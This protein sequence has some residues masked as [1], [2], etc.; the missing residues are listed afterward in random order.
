MFTL[1]A[2]DINIIYSHD[3]TISL[4]NIINT[5]LEKLYAWFNFNKLS[6]NFRKTN[7]VAFS[8]NN[9]DSIIDISVNGS[10]IEK[11]NSAKY[12]GVYVDRRLN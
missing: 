3:S 5:E 6:L 7:Y 8:T 9:L 12:L 4:C 2:D 1:F 11:V 10:N